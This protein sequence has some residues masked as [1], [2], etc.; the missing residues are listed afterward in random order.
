MNF[1]PD[2]VKKS[3]MQWVLP[4][5]MLQ[6]TDLAAR[7][8]SQVCA[9]QYT[10]TIDL[11]NIKL[12]QTKF[13][14]A[15]QPEAPEPPAWLAQRTSS[16]SARLI[17]THRLFSLKTLT[18]A[19]G[20]EAK[21]PIEAVVEYSMDLKECIAA[22]L[23]DYAESSS[24][25]DRSFPDRLLR[26]DSESDLSPEQLK[27]ELASVEA[28]RRRLVSAGLLDPM[29]QVDVHLADEIEKTDKTTRSVL[30]VYVRDVQEKLKFFDEI[31][32]K[33]DAFTSIINRHFQ[34]K[35]I[36][37]SKDTGFAVYSTVD[38]TPVPLTAL[39]SGEQHELVLYYQLLFK[40]D[41]DSLIM[42]DEPE[43][44]LHVAWQKLFL[45]DLMDVIKH[46]QFDVLIATHSPQII[47][48]RWDLTV[49][50]GN[51]KQ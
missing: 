50:L 47:H 51:P 33:I 32:G 29:E 21:Q 15:F 14:D 25:L 42:V 18:R 26:R 38:S 31:A 1:S 11:S 9:D 48:D 16:I 27:K 17:E 35:Q 49:Q 43:I 10:R 28:K 2:D 6:D 8:V 44:S 3:A 45:S 24:K 30:S 36:K 19:K 22:Y 12:S 39:S 40:T 13:Y 37:I 41:K 23:R 46:S 34:Y 7:A 5:V 4:N 20:S